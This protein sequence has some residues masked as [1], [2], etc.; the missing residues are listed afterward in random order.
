[1]A[2]RRV[3]LMEAEARAQLRALCAE[4]RLGEDLPVDGGAEALL[5]DRA[6]EV[7]RPAATQQP[8]RVAQVVARVAWRA[9]PSQQLRL[10]R[11]ASTRVLVVAN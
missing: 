10:E 9:Q 7:A 2:L 6:T 1:M 11:T 3:L 4:R 8:A 5:V